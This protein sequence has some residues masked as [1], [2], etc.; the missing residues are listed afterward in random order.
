MKELVRVDE[1]AAVDES[2]GIRTVALTRKVASGHP[3]SDKKH[4]NPSHSFLDLLFCL[5]PTD[6]R[7]PDGSQRARKRNSVAP[8]GQPWHKGKREKVAPPGQGG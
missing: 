4:S 6:P 8:N 7:L 3:G 5:S 2:S 1:K